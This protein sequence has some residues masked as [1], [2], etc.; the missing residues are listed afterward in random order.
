[1]LIKGTFLAGFIWHLTIGAAG[2]NTRT[3]F[4]LLELP[5]ADLLTLTAFFFANGFAETAAVRTR[6]DLATGRPI[7]RVV[8]RWD[9]S[10]T[11]GDGPH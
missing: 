5:A 2:A 11:N 9:P 10:H 7:C 4:G 6:Q 1:M 8:L 3:V